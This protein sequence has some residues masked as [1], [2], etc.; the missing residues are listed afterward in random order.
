MVEKRYPSGETQREMKSKEGFREISHT[1]DWELEVW[2]STI[3]AL[4]RQ[5]ALG[6]FALMRVKVRRS[7]RI[8]KEI[9]LEIYDW[10]SLLVDFLNEV[11]YWSE[12]E[13][14]GFDEYEIAIDGR[15]LQAEICGFP[16][17]TQ[18]KEIKAVTYHNLKIQK[19]QEGFIT[20]IVFD[21]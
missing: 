2:G 14:I 5:A 21:V 17:D 8:C 12:S 10:E 15:T 11:L 16:V 3:D 6:M 19:T 13:R 1:A 18:E 7:V 9:E 4:L 20:R